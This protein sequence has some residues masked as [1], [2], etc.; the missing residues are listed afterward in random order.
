M[1]KRILAALAALGVIAT[2]SAAWASTGSQNI[3]VIYR[4]IKLV[5]N[6]VPVQTSAEPFIYNGTTYLPVRAVSEALG[7]DV[8]WDGETSTVYVGKQPEGNYLTDIEPYYKPDYYYTGFFDSR[9][10]T[11]LKTGGT[12]Y[13]KIS[14]AKVHSSDDEAVVA[15]NLNGQYQTL[16]GLVGLDDNDDYNKDL[17]VEVTFEGDGYPLYTFTLSPGD[18]PK[19]VSFSVSGVLQLKARIRPV[20]KVHYEHYAVIVDFADMVLK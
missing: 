9:T 6:G 13:G 1:K 5:V 8:S 12:A 17:V 16:S 7:Q 10:K 15:W 14:G 18:L 3:Q 19:Q 20:K 11:P 2:A 4:N